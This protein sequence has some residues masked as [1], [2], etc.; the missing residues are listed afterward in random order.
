MELIDQINL[1]SFLYINL[2]I[3]LSLQCILNSSSYF[4][5]YRKSIQKKRYKQYIKLLFSS[6]YIKK[7]SI[8]SLFFAILVFILWFYFIW[9]SLK[10]FGEIILRNNP[11]IL[12]P[13][14]SLLLGIYIVIIPVFIRLAY[15]FWDNLMF[16]IRIIKGKLLWYG[17]WFWYLLKIQLKIFN[18]KDLERFY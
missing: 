13:S 1:V 14:I 2:F 11:L 12:Y 9:L 10:L 15:L 5:T 17:T 7:C 16:M 6:E 18:T 4:H 3:Y 8:Q